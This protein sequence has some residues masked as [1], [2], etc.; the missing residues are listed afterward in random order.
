MFRDY[1]HDLQ[2]M[3]SFSNCFGFHLKSVVGSWLRDCLDEKNLS[4]T[5]SSFIH[6]IRTFVQRRQAICRFHHFLCLF[7]AQVQS[8][9]WSAESGGPG[10]FANEAP[11]WLQIPEG[12]S[13]T[14]ALSE[15]LHPDGPSG[16][17]SEEKRSPETVRIPSFS[18]FP[19]K[20]F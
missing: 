9:H 17:K 14:A 19:S 1:I 6:T 12:A 2:L 5:I 4:Q 13:K 16:E 3:P 18:A 8:I 15:N 7:L 10:D 11:L 20:S